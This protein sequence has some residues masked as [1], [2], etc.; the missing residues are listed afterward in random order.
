MMKN[1]IVTILTG[2]SITAY[3]QVSKVEKRDYSNMPDFYIDSVKVHI[4]SLLYKGPNVLAKEFEFVERSK[5]N[6]KG[7]IYHKSKG[8]G[9]S[10]LLTLQEIEK[11]YTGA[12]SESTVFMI[13]DDFLIDPIATYKVDSSYILDVVL[14]KSSEVDYLKGRTPEFSIFKIVL[15]NKENLEKRNQ[16]MIR[17]NELVKRD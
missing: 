7:S 9:A 10:M 17:G 2:L 1:T 11:V 15:K 16:I 4:N 3:G 5:T 14:L 13:N 8:Q 12:V 6:P